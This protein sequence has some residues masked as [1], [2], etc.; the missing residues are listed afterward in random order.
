MFHRVDIHA[1]LVCIHVAVY[2]KEN[3][4]HR[5]RN[6]CV[7]ALAKPGAGILRLCRSGSMK[8][9]ADEGSRH[10][11]EDVSDAV[12]DGRTTVRRTS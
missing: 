8:D 7:V 2:Y 5:G 9:G 10:R 11:C 3:A 6:C 1:H 12:F 4:H